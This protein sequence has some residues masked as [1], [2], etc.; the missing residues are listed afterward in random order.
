MEKG[1]TTLPGCESPAPVRPAL[2]EDTCSVRLSDR[3]A[4]EVMA[5][6]DNPPAPNAAALNA[7]KRFLQRD[8]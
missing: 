6:A 7:A 1:E 2:P 4:A 8:G 3:D 5:T